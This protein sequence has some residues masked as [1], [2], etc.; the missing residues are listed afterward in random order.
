MALFCLPIMPMKKYETY[1]HSFASNIVLVLLSACGIAT[2]SQKAFANYSRLTVASWL[3]DVYIFQY[4][5]LGWVYQNNIFIYIFLGMLVIAFFALLLKSFRNV[6]HFDDVKEIDMKVKALYN[7]ETKSS[8]KL[9][10][11]AVTNKKMKILFKKVMKQ[12][13]IVPPSAIHQSV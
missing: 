8:N 9:T 11:V 6:E 10:G 1:L 5:Y 7:R 13:K 3:F 4:P 12:K 2:F